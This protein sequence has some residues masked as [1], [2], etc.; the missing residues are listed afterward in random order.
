MIRGGVS[1]LYRSRGAARMQ[2]RL[3]SSFLDRINAELS[4]IKEAG[5]WKSERVIAS[6][7]VSRSPSTP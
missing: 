2:H 7:Q 6:T 3:M 1:A 5:L 4:S